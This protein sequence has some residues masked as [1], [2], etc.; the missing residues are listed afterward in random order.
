[1]LTTRDKLWV[2]ALFCLWVETQEIRAM[3]FL[4]DSIYA[5]DVTI[6]IVRIFIVSIRFTITNVYPWPCYKR[7][8]LIHQ[9]SL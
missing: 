5:C 4:R 1:M 8:K 3:I 9:Y 2:V 7:N 6:T